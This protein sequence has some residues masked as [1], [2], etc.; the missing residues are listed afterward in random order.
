VGVIAVLVLAITLVSVVVLMGGGVVGLL[1]STPT[2]TQT[3]VVTPTP[4][5]LPSNVAGGAEILPTF[6]A[7]TLKATPGGSDLL[8]VPFPTDTLTP[9]LIND[10]LCIG[11]VDKSHPSLSS[12]LRSFQQPYLKSEKYYRCTQLNTEKTQCEK[13]EEIVPHAMVHPG[14]WII[15]PNVDKNACLMNGGTWVQDATR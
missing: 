11:K 1:F 13:K 14:Q 2:P 7:T 6:P 10:W 9:A 5:P 12:V 15:I 8:S 4:I 3:S